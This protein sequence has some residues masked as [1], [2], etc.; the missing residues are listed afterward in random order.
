MAGVTIGVITGDS[1]SRDG[2]DLGESVD[3]VEEI[4]TGRETVEVAGTS[5]KMSY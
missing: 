5:L 3:I 1:S 2:D 4:G